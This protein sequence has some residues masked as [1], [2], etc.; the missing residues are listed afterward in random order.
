MSIYEAV[1]SLIG[2]VPTGTEPIVYVFCMI[3]ALFVTNSIVSF[4]FSFFKR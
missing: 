3:L 1:I 2:D 4:V